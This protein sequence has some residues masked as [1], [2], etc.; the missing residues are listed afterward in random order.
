M[1]S[2]CKSIWTVW[3]IIDDFWF[4]FAETETL[5]IWD[6]RLFNEW[7]IAWMICQTSYIKS[8]FSS[9]RV[10]ISWNLFLPKERPYNIHIKKSAVYAEMPSWRLVKPYKSGHYITSI[11]KA[12]TKHFFQWRIINLYAFCTWQALLFYLLRKYRCHKSEAST[13]KIGFMIVS[14]GFFWIIHE[15]TV[16]SIFKKS[17][18]KGMFFRQRIFMLWKQVRFPLNVPHEIARH[19]SRFYSINGV[20]LGES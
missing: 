12:T 15:I 19:I 3:W 2:F 8:I 6:H 16:P 5:D 13:P 4:L 20:Y 17:T 1:R 7:N 11:H 18:F 9:K 14:S 10:K